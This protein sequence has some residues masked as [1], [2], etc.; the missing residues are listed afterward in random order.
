MLRLLRFEQ[1]DV[2]LMLA[3]HTSDGLGR[4]IVQFESP[5]ILADPPS[6]HGPVPQAASLHDARPLQ[7]KPSSH[8]DEM[9]LQHQT[10][11]TAAT[12]LLG[13]EL[14]VHQTFM[15]AINGIV[16]ESTPQQITKLEKLEG[17]HE[18]VADEVLHVLSDTG[19]DWIGAPSLWNGT[20]TGNLPGSQGEGIIVGVI[21]TGINPLNPSFAAVGPVDGYVHVN[22]LGAG[23]YLGVCTGG[24][25][26]NFGCNDKLI[27]AYNFTGSGNPLDDDSHGSHT[28]STAAGNTVDAAVV[29][30]DGQNTIQRIS[31]V[32][33][34]ANI[35]AYD[36]C[37]GQ[38]CAL[39]SL[40][41][42]IDQAIM[43]GVDVINYSIEGSNSNPW[44][45][46]VAT[47]FRNARDAGIFVSVAAGNDGPDADTV[48]SPTTAPWVTSVGATTH[49]RVFANTVDVIAPGPVPSEFLGIA[50]LV[51]TGPVF[52][53]DVGPASLVYSGD[54]SPGNDLGCSAFPVGSM[55]GSIALIQRGICFFET[56][57]N[58][59][60]AAG[61][62]AVLVF[63]HLGGP[64]IV[65]AMLEST[66]IPAGFMTNTDG[67][68]LR[69]FVQANSGVTVRINDS[70]VKVIQPELADVMADFSSRGPD[71]TVDLITPSLTAP[72]VNVLAAGGTN[73]S[74]E[75]QFHSGTSMATPHVAGAAALLMSLHPNWTPAEVQSALMT[76][77]VTESIFKEDGRTLAD[78]FDRGAG[79]INLNKS[80]QAGIVLD[81][82]TIA[83]VAANPNSN[84]DPT[85]LNLPSFSK[86][87]I[88]SQ[89]A[90]TR[91]LKSTQ[92]VDVN[93]TVSFESDAELGLLSA[94][95]V[96]HLPAGGTATMV[97]IAD[98]RS[99]SVNQR[100]YGHVTLTPD[101]AGIP[102]ATFPVATMFTGPDTFPPVL[103]E[104]IPNDGQNRPDRLTS[105]T[106]VF[107]QNVTATL[108]ADDLA[109]FNETTGAPVDLSLAALDAATG[110]WDLSAVSLPAAFYRA[111]LSAA[112]ITDTAGNPLDGDGD[113]TGGDDYV[114]SLLVAIP[115]DAS[116]DGTV[117][118]NDFSIWNANQFTNGSWEQAD[119]TH[120]GAVDIR[121][122]NQWNAH[123][124]T[125]V[126]PFG[127][128]TGGTGPPPRAALATNPVSYVEPVSVA[129]AKSV[130]PL[131]IRH[132]RKTDLHA[133]DQLPVKSAIALG[134]FDP[135]FRRDSHLGTGLGSRHLVP[136]QLTPET[137][138]NLFCQ[139]NESW[140]H[141]ASVFSHTPPR[142]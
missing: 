2:R 94:E 11:L 52:A 50:A 76:T 134:G 31:G 111:T 89:H 112:G 19:L 123:K 46:T 1:L 61:A 129:M 108:T 36:A 44:T 35:I 30:D 29:L 103:N 104:V 56:K 137:V 115:G 127:S 60:A 17:V 16:I 18:I 10:F 37:T 3:G 92:S 113:G 9:E 119:F 74:V 69:D 125:T 128:L 139:M 142:T 86:N 54:V 87:N 43:D 65:M 67:E 88:S 66:T 53:A 102:N 38:S 34:H 26:Q 42:A 107:D 51:G 48:N 63:N 5:S 100:L 81:E 80:A 138:D 73:G 131:E 8:R 106:F 83:Y 117:D 28:S 133:S 120:D 72:G 141:S 59:A 32:A 124:F 64:P 45:D 121:D 47:S 39:S 99:A 70:V 55:Q 22:P 62:D 114:Q 82:S 68:A 110:R 79:R 135:Q 96:I 14:T 75:W 40:V 33:P 13:T 130:S 58:N 122:L 84:G 77:A 98:L 24:D 101:V 93:W 140:N 57:V 85:T 6:I 7:L 90:W 20:S 97:I 12:E 95:E 109:L 118:S 27:G 136:T 105:L 71:A 126:I 78:P 49:G 91:T 4:Y 21:D 132:L 25:L 15:A 23:N 116:L 41:Q